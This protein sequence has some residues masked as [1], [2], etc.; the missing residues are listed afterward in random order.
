MNEQFV[1][2]KGYWASFYSAESRGR[3][4]MP[5]SQFAAFVAQELE[6][7]SAIFDVGCGNGRDSLFFAEMGFKVVSLD[8]SKDAIRFVEEQAKERDLENIK[9]IVGDIKGPKLREAI[10]QLESKKVCIYAR[11]FLHAISE[12]EQEIFLET[13][14]DNLRP[15]SLVAFEYRTVDDQFLQK[16]A[17]PHFRRYQSSESLKAKLQDAGFEEIYAIEGQGFAKYKMD[18]AIVARCIFE[19]V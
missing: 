2:R 12:K 15:G 9:F 11:F 7:A 4:L 13:L 3:S 1:D 5:P 10:E 19:K 14:S 8:G 18:D 17:P 16:E 6:P